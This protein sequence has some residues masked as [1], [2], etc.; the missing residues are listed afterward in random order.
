MKWEY[1]VQEKGL[2][3]CDCTTSEYIN[4]AT[5]LNVTVEIDVFEGH[6]V[7]VADRHFICKLST[8]TEYFWT[9][10]EL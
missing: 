6:F 8:S 9:I 7:G 10:C 5:I 2:P 1:V 3:V 4:L